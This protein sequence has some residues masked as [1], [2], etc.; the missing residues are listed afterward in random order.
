MDMYHILLAPGNY[1]QVLVQKY[2]LTVLMF[3]YMKGIV[4][5]NSP[6]ILSQLQYIIIDGLDCIQMTNTKTFL[7]FTTSC[8][9]Q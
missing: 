1:Q 7:G 2:R 3:M 8:Y 6:T 9:K 5:S 4:F